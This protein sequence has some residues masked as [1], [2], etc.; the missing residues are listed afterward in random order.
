MTKSFLT[1]TAGIFVATIFALPAMADEKSFDYSDFVE[2]DSSAGVNVDIS[3]GG[4][5]SIV[6]TGSEKALERLRIEI[7]GDTLYVGRKKSVSWGRTPSVQVA[8]TMPALEG[9]EAS[10]GS[11]IDADG[12]SGDDFSA[13]ASSGA[14]IVVE[15][16]CT[17]LNVDV[18]SGA[19]INAEDLKCA[20]V[21]A[22]GSSGGSISATANE[23]VIADASSGA[24]I[25]IYGSPKETNIDKSSGGSVKIK[26]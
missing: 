23:K 17:D 5:Y 26:K 6:A 14:S 19:S 12:I 21:I 18:S 8:V 13:D 10:S 22:D 2:V 24:S 1:C 20:E 9:V 16:T 25:R 7:K 11:S 3:V 15:G 4:D